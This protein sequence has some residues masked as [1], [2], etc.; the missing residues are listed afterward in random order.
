MDMRRNEVRRIS[1]APE[2]TCAG[3]N[4]RRNELRRIELRRIEYAPE[5][6]APEWTRADQKQIKSSGFHIKKMYV[7]CNVFLVYV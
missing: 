7:R 4:M 3:L 5:W 2:W 1:L 6:T